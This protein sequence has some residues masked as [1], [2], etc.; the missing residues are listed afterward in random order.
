MS[1]LQRPP[2]S[3]SILLVLAGAA[4]LAPGASDPNSAGTAAPVTLTLEQ[5]IDLALHHN[6]GV[7]AAGHARAAASEGVIQSRARF[8]PRL[9]AMETVSWTDN[10][11][12]VFS[13]LLGQARFSRA[14]FEIA[15]LNE[16]APLANFNARVTL[17]QPIYAGGQLDAGRAAA[18]HI[19]EAAGGEERRARQQTTYGTTRAYHGVLLARAQLGVAEAAKGAAASHLKTA[20][21]LVE[22]GLAVPSDVMRV[23]VRLEEIE[24]MRIRAAAGE[25]VARA[26]LEAVMGARPGSPYDLAEPAGDDPPL[27]EVEEASRRA[28]ASRPDLAAARSGASASGEGVRAAS[29]GWKPQIGFMGAYEINDGSLLGASGSNWAAMVT[30][31]VNV[32]DGRLTASRVRQSREER[33]RAE[34]LV[35]GFESQV[36]MEVRQAHAELQGAFARREAARGAVAQAE[37][38]LRI[39]RDR[40]ENGMGTVTDLLDGETALTD[41]RARLASAAYDCRNGAAALDLATGTQGGTPEEARR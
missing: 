28:L 33:E 21:N 12:M 10:P 27:P 35:S 26:A 15:S 39:V 11:T 40:Y 29:A 25:R 8:L 22:S 14:N 23:K 30:V 6:P 5:A 7:V 41:A 17:T 2:A 19:E 13:N 36:V 18:R 34:S 31:G 9:D 16:P 37:E 1:Q 20:Q 4:G 32:F 38:G 24:E 3:L